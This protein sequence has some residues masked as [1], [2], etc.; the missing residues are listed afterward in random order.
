MFADFAFLP[1]AVIAEFAA[2]LKSKSKA[3]HQWQGLIVFFTCFFILSV[4]LRSTGIGGAAVLYSILRGHHVGYEVDLIS[5]GCG[6]DKHSMG[7][8]QGHHMENVLQLAI[9]L[10][11]SPF[12]STFFSFGPFVF[13]PAN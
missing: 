5:G 6:L 2:D 12:I 7:P 8:R 3:R 13:Q 9:S 4:M 10:S 1:G 11:L